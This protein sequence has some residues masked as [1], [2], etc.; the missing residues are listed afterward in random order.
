MQVTLYGE[1]LC[2]YC[3]RFTREVV[4]PLLQE[5]AGLSGIFNFSYVAWGNAVRT[6][7]VRSHPAL[8]PAHPRARSLMPVCY[9]A[10]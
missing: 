6:E 8:P 7:D 2:P 1:A 10:V 3:A 5:D 4:A 9:A